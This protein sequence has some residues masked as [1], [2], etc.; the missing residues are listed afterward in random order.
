MAAREGLDEDPE[1]EG[2]DKWCDLCN[3]GEQTTEH[4][5]SI[6]EKLAETR[7]SFFNDPFPK[8]PY[9]SI[10]LNAL[11]SFLKLVKLKQLEMYGSYEE[12]LEDLMSDDASDMSEGRE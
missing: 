5:L 7:Q 9:M 11:I 10:K 1:W 8:P 3:G 6:C 2:P 4:I 12:Y